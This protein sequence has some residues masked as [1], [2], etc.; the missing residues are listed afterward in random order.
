MPWFLLACA[1]FLY[2]HLFRLPSTPVFT[3]GDQ[4]VYLVGGMRML[5]GQ[6]LYRDF[7]D[8][9]PPGAHLV[10]FLL[11][12]TLGVHA[13]IPNL[14]LMILG[15]GL[16][17]LTTAITRRIVQGA[18]AYLPGLVFLTFS[19]RSQLD[20]THH[21]YS[22]L[23]AL[24]ALA[25]ALESRTPA[26]ILAA[27]ALCG[28]AAFFTQPRGTM[29]LFGFAVFLAWEA[30][31]K[32]SGA[33]TLIRNEALLAAGFLTTIAALLIRFMMQAGL[34]PVFNST[35][36]FLLRY[37][38]AYGWNTWAAY[39]AERPS[40]HPWYRL[41]PLA[42]WLFMNVCQPVIYLLCFWRYRQ[43]RHAADGGATTPWDRWMLVFL[44]GLAMFAA[45]LRAPSSLR[46]AADSLPV[47]I[48]LG[49][50]VSS[51]HPLSW[52]ARRTLW[53][54]ALALL[55]STPMARQIVY[56][57]VDLDLP[58]GR[59][60]FFDLE[61]AAHFEWFLGR[62]QPGQY[63]FGSTSFNFYL[64]LPDPAPVPFVTTTDF[65][66]PEQV[67][68]LVEALERLRVPW[69][70]G[71][72]ELDLAGQGSSGGDHLDPLRDELRQHY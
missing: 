21:W 50:L 7:F 13:W 2:L 47:L 56:S 36:T 30:R 22:A 3:I 49:W 5:A 11:F 69:V 60:A 58:A 48:L 15:L 12:R 59:T 31:D 34:A 17:W 26:R 71:W 27:G 53:A 43:A 8:F 25:V 65:T 33:R 52:L 40:L 67:R 55:V 16:T 62:V 57:P 10:Y 68:D 9:L 32:R 63:F 66:R 20:A 44:V 42:V 23:A 45:T 4:D 29:A 38:T 18:T 39:L 37:S 19:F 46:L 54:A 6:V 51:S 14:M 28:V 35:V 24:A 72:N 70:L 1:A 61:R 64:L 41:G